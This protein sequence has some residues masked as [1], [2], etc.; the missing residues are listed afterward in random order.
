MQFDEKKLHKLQ[1]LI[2]SDETFSLSFGEDEKEDHLFVHYPWYIA[3]SLQ[4]SYYNI[5]E[6]LHEEDIRIR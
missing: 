1:W 4:G 5:C 3:E 2:A 6:A